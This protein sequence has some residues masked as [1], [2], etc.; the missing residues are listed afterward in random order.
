[1][2]KE[3]SQLF[4]LFSHFILRSEGIRTNHPLVHFAR[5]V[6]AAFFVAYYARLQYLNTQY[7]PEGAKAIDG[8]IVGRVTSDT[9]THYTFFL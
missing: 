9:V 6:N 5:I 3:N 7:L 4:H 2:T 1:M 8:M